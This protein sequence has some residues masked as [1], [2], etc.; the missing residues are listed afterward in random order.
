MMK[1]ILQLKKLPIIAAILV[2]AISDS[3]AQ[4]GPAGIGSST[5]NVLWLRSDRGTSTTTNGNPLSGWNDFSGNANHS[6]QATGANQP[7]YISAGINGLPT[8]R[9]D[10]NDYLTVPDADNLDNTNGVSVFVVAKP[11]VVSNPAKGLV[12]KRVDS[13]TER[14]YSLFIGENSNSYIIFDAGNN[15]IRGS[16]SYTTDPQVFSAVYNG[17]L[18]SNQSK[19]FSNGTLYTEGTGPSSLGNYSSDLHIGILNPGYAQGLAGDI[20]EVIV[21][22]SSLNFAERSIV[23]AYLG[24]RYNISLG[25]TSY[26]SSTFNQDIV[27]IGFSEGDKLSNTPN[28]GSGILLSERNNTLDEANEFVFAGHDGTVHGHNISD[29]PTISGVNLDQ[30]WDRIYY[31]ERV[32]GGTIDNG[33]TDIQ[34]IFDFNEAGLSF[35]TDKVYYILYRSGTSGSFSEVPGGTGA[36]SDGKVSINISSANFV[37]GYYTIARSDQEIKT[38]YVL[39]DG[40][41]DDYNTW[42]LKPTEP[43][44][45]SNDIPGVMD[46]VVVQDNKAVTVR[47]DN[48]Q[49]GVLDVIDGTVDF[50]TTTGN[51]FSSI[52]GQIN[53]KIRLAADNFPSGDASGFASASTGGTVIY[54]GAGYDLG[55]T[56]TFRNMVVDL[57]DAANQLILLTNYTL[58]GSLTISN[59]ELHFGNTSTTARTLTVY[60]H[61]EV[62]ANGKILTGTGITRHQFNLYGDFTNYGNV[63]FTTR[64]AVNYTVDNADGIVDVNFRSATR[65]QNMLLEGPTRFYRI[66]IEKGT[67]NTYELYMEATDAS[68]FSLLGYAAQGHPDQAQLAVNNNAFGLAYGT[69]RVGPNITIDRLNQGG[70]YNVSENAILW[71]DGGSV[72]KPSGTGEAVVVYGRIKISSG[73]FTSNAPSGITARLNGVFES[74]G[75]TTVISQFRTSVYGTQHIGGYI[76]TGGNV[77]VNGTAANTNYYSFSLSYEGNVFSLTGGTM[78][79]NGTNSRGAIFINSDP[80]NVNVSA[81]A[82]MNLIATNTTPFRITSRAPL[83]TV[84]LSRSGAAGDRSFILVG[85]IVGTDASNQAELPALPLVTKGSFTINNDIIFDPRGEDVTIGRSY[86]IGSNSSYNAYSNTTTFSGATTNYSISINASATTKYFHNLAFNNSGYTGTLNTSDITI[87]NN[88]TITAGTF[89]T[90]DR[91]V[92]VRGDITNSGTITST[93]GKV[94]ITQRGRVHTVNLTNG[95]SYTSVPTVTFSAGTATAIAIFNGTPSAGNPLPISKIVITNTGSGYTAVPAVNI[96]GGGGAIATAVIGTTHILGGDGNG[97]FGNLDIDEVHP[98]EAAGKVEVTYLT[99]KQTVSG[100][101]TLTNGILDLRTNNLTILGSLSTEDRANYSVTK[102]I[103]SGGVHSD[104]GL[105]RRIISDNIPYLYP[106]GVY[107]STGNGNR[108]TPAVQTFSSVIDE[109][110]VTI[111]P[112]D[113]ELPTLAPSAQSALRYY[114]RVRAN[115]FDNTPLVFNDFYFYNIPNTYIGGVTPPAAWVIGKIV[116]LIRVEK[117]G[118]RSWSNPTRLLGLHFTHQS[119][120]ESGATPPTLETGE[121][122]AGH[123]TRFQGTVKVFFSRLRGTSAAQRLWGEV[124]SWTTLAQVATRFGLTPQQVMDQPNIWHL[125][126]NPQ[127]NAGT[128]TT[129]DKV[130]IGWVPWDDPVVAYRGDPH[131]IRNNGGTINCAELIF[132]PMKTAS[133]D[134][135]PRQYWDTYFFRPTITLTGGTTL[136]TPIISGEGTI[137]NRDQDTDFSNIDLGDFVAQDSSYMLY[138]IFGAVTNLNNI[139]ESL[140]NLII[141]PDGWGEFDK[142]AV[143]PKDITVNNNLEV[144]GAA[145]LRLNTGVL[146]NI[147]IKG[148]LRLQQAYRY[149]LGIYYTNTR[150]EFQNSGTPR[151]VTIEGDIYTEGTVGLYVLTP[152]TTPIQHTLNLYGSYIQNATASVLGAGQP[153]FRLWTATD[154]DRVLLNLVGSTDALLSGTNT[155]TTAILYNLQVDKGTSTTTL[156]TINIPFT[157]NGPT[158]GLSE[159]KALQLKN[160]KLTLNNSAININLSTGG[161]DFYIPSTSGLVVQSGTVNV[162]GANNG[163]LLDGLLRVEAGGTIN[164]DGGAGFNNYIEYSSSGNAAIE[165]TG[166]TFT[167][168]SQIRRGTS[169]PAGVLRYTQTAGN[170]VVGKNAAPVANR[171]TFEVLNT[172]SRFIYTGGTLTIVRPQTLAT[173]A[174]VLLEPAVGSAGNT[175]LQLGNADTPAASVITLKSTIA[176]GNLTVDGASTTARLKDRDLTVNRDLTIGAGCS[177]DGTGFFSLTVNRHLVNSGTAN[178]NVDTLF[179]TGSSTFPSAAMQNITGN[180]RVNHLVVEPE[181][182]VTLQPASSLEIDGNLFLNSGQLV[183][184]A[185]IITVKGDVTNNASHVS[186]NPGVGGM[187]FAGSALQ[188]IYG[189]GQFGRIEVNNSNGVQLENSISLNNHLTITNGILQ[190]QSNKL[191]LGLNADIFGGPFNDNKMIAVGGGDFLQG[192][193]KTFPEVASATPTDPYNENDPAYSYDFT[194]P[195]GVDNGT[196]KKY[197]PVDFHVASSA[198]QGSVNLYPVNR[199]HITFDATQTDVLQYYWIMN[200]SGLSNFTSLIHTHYK[201]IA[202]G[203]DVVGDESAYI[204]AKLYDNFWAKYEEKDEVIGPPYEPAIE[205]VYEGLDYVAF[206]SDGVNTITGE[207]T[208]GIQPHIPDLVPLFYSR[209]NGDWTDADTWEREDGGIVPEGGP[210]GQRV[211]IRTAHTVTIPETANF[212]RAYRTTINGRLNLGTTKNHILGYVSGTG[213]LS[214]ATS[215]LPAGDYSAFFA[216]GTGGTMEWTGGTYGLPSSITS[217]NNLTITGTG[218]KTFPNTNIT[219]CGDLRIEGNVTLKQAGVGA[220]FLNTFIEK[221]VYL[222]NTTIWDMNTRARIFLKGD[223]LKDINARINTSGYSGH[224]FE[225]RGVDQEFSG[226]FISTSKF[227][228][229][230]YNHSGIALMNGPVDVSLALL[231]TNGRVFTTSTNILRAT[232]TPVGSGLSEVVN[233]F[234]EGPISI[235]LRSSD[236]PVKYIPVGRNNVRKFIYPLDIPST[237][238]TWIGEYFNTSPTNHTPSMSHEN[239]VGPILTVSQS[240]YWQLTAP[241]DHASHLQLTFNGTSDIAAA[242]GNKDN[243]RIVYWNGTHWQMLGTGATITDQFTGT[244]T[245]TGSLGTFKFTGTQQYFTIGAIEEVE[246]LTATITSANQSICQSDT[247]NLEVAIVGNYPNFEVDYS[248]GAANFTESGIS[249]LDP[250]ITLSVPDLSLGVNTITLTAIRD[251]DSPINTGNIIGT[252]SVTV[253]V[254]ADHPKPPTDPYPTVTSGGNICGATTTT[255]ELDGSVVGFTYELFRDGIYFDNLPGTGGPLTFYDIDQEGIYTVEAYNTSFPS[256]VA[257]MNGFADIVFGS[258]ASAQVTSLISDANICEGIPVEMQITFTGTPPF[259]F[260]VEDNYGG[261]WAGNV[262]DVGDLTGLGPYTYNFTIPDQ[263]PTWTA[264]DLPNIYNYN[265]TA[266]DDSSGCVGGNIVGTGVNVNVYKTPETGPQYHVPNTFGE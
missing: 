207:Y 51:A 235:N 18:G 149:D 174:T 77:T 59:G 185:N 143:I 243:L 66:A 197:T 241:L 151:T 146:G 194:F 228:V 26:S 173:E 19:I 134:P 61:L 8:I 187:V 89:G 170:V 190:L 248:I 65:N 166:G 212:R 32:Q 169:N 231:L 52:T 200:S 160:G 125:S 145:R 221:N 168:G 44:N 209:K 230:K 266:I 188:R 38:W 245:S 205:V 102:M 30:R 86:T 182:S 203:N 33:T 58:N 210:V 258:A 11:D 226:N 56:R 118:N 254:Y 201:D 177:F 132:N 28:V 157:L 189:T 262:V 171:G 23:E 184:G 1:N 257:N 21:Y 119:A 73:T 196:V 95:G 31:I 62:G 193:Q 94:L 105:T 41:W 93:T 67:T 172:G 167:V 220:G 252:T 251:S 17:A 24:N 63:Q 240:E 142:A 106:F 15:R 114:W 70:N 112:V 68:Y 76:Q 121:F 7:L 35:S 16:S 75:G 109:G 50:G 153:I 3:Y 131:N 97:V 69:V 144:H 181:A 80:V 37:S 103:R 225:L 72:T 147:Y 22:R 237:I 27:G 150:F 29:L 213:T 263:Y 82:T 84:T 115:D 234:V 199:K 192:I 64:A 202:P 216:C 232:R 12:S 57:D 208:A 214:S 2:L 91:T 81:S 43:D 138:E 218:T 253:T 128:P 236:S 6:A 96:T 183:D 152:S 5:N 155:T 36:A 227:Y 9:F 47:L 141:A 179:L 180:V 123:N 217:Y 158:N 178:L 164:M 55:V 45:P 224:S 244:I 88:L 110:L 111:N 25:N 54:Y 13:S 156:A 99:A 92:T 116:N 20:S 223:F 162:S 133:G 126:D 261:I 264:P 137:R 14:A 71:V 101:F 49:S 74:T 34:I 113:Y 127:S 122:T 175:T 139:P 120:N 83:P 39:N 87:G 165:V 219:I 100:T 40:Y 176:L 136:V 265:V 250:T 130:V 229:L 238:G 222:L 246:L 42:S 198:T 259:T 233:G 48:T 98:S 108:Y 204:G 260:T 79:I 53:G 124:A 242:V 104:G 60:E 78:T 148:D 239:K 161:D 140:P 117:P 90:G 85:G 255:V 249:T 186:S 163:I 195:I 135:A 46:R 215:S 256:C 129:G 4:T 154:Q 10:G 159:E 211:H 206:V 107:T 247:Y 191:T